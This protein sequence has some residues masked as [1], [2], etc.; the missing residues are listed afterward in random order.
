MC[1]FSLSPVVDGDEQFIP[2]A[3]DWSLL[4]RVAKAHPSY[5]CYAIVH[6]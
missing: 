3:L 6:V 2:G 5:Y 4:L 1:G